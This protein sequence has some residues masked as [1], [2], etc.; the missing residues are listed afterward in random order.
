[1]AKTELEA[2]LRKNDD[3]YGDSILLILYETKYSI[4]RYVV[5]YS[6]YMSDERFRKKLEKALSA[7]D[8]V[9]ERHLI[10]AAQWIDVYSNK[11]LPIRVIPELSNWEE[12]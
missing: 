2:A 9:V 5:R 10:T 3:L 7:K 8:M 12:I 1:M 11:D 4:G 6:Y